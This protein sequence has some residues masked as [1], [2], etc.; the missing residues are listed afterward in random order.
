MVRRVPSVGTGSRVG[1]LLP[2]AEASGPGYR[3]DLS[4]SHVWNP[5]SPAEKMLPYGADD[6][7]SDV[8]DFF[9]DDDDDLS[10]DVEDIED[11]DD[12]EDDEDE[13]GDEWDDDDD[14]EAE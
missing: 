8:S 4:R 11:D 2:L 1:L 5:F 9:D 14:D 10:D 7:D 3:C 13:D 6:F 12:D